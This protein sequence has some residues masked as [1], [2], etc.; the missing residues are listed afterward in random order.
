MTRVIQIAGIIILLSVGAVTF[1]FVGG[2][3]TEKHL[4]TSTPSNTAL[5]EDVKEITTAQPPIRVTLHRTQFVSQ[6]FN[7]CGP[8][9]LSMVMSF[10]GKAVPQQE[11]AE[12]MRPFNNPLG[13]VDDKSIFA[14][15][16][17]ATAKEYGFESLHRP[18]GDLELLK[19]FTANGIPVVVRTWLNPNEDIGHFRIVR[20]YDDTT[21][22]ILQDDSYQGPNLSYSYT[23]FMNMWKP[24]NYGYILVYPKE[25][26]VVVDAILGEEKDEKIA[27]QRTL[28]RAEKEL[29]ENPN[30]P[31]VLFNIA[32]ASYYLGKSD[33]TI[34][35]YEKA[36]D[37]LPARML[38]YQYE[39]LEAYLKKQQYDIVFRLTDEILNN[40]NQAYSELYVLRGKAYVQ[41][42]RVDDATEEFEKAVH[43]NKNSKVAREAL[44]SVL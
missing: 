26:Q 19:Q 27:W 20:G 2:K 42:G 33:Q 37:S 43:Y 23:D 14:P 15:E 6:T 24:F 11:L 38:W 36:K 4:T 5:K 40:G 30:D 22:T 21:Q 35:Y 34:S 7:N 29:A 31:Y 9:S 32:T 18:N 41:Q 44:A 13:G 12:K 8:A 28:A 10:Y 16:F 3:D 39:P 1:Q 25:Q 17:V